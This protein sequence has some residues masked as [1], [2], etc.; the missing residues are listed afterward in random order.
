MR[1]LK[2][3]TQVRIGLGAVLAL[4]LALGAVA[5]VQ[6]DA[7]WSQT[8]NLYEHPLQVRRAVGDLKVDVLL[9]QRAVK[10]LCLA[11]SAQEQV[12]I[13]QEM[14]IREAAALRELEIL[15]DR[16]LGPHADVDAVHRHF[17]AWN[18]LRDETIQLVRAGKPAEAT[19]R[20]R[21]NDAGSAQV[22][23]L[24]GLIQVIDDFARNKG[25]S[26]YR[27]AEA[28][29]DTL[30]LRLVVVMGAIL[31]LGL[32]VSSLLLGRIQRPLQALTSAMLEYGQGKPD[33]RC[34]HVSENEFGTVATA[35]N[36]LADTV[37]AETVLKERAAELNA[38]MLRELESGTFRQGLLEALVRLTGSQVGA[39]YL[40]NPEKTAYQ[41]L[42]SIGLGGAARAAFSAAEREGEFGMALASGKVQHIA[43]IPAN[44]H[45]TFGAVS[46]DFSPKEILTIP[47]LSGGETPAMIS[48]ASLHGYAGG[49]VRLVEDMQAALSAWINGMLA[50]RRILALNDRLAD[51]NS[52]LEAQKNEL[53]AQASELGQQNVELEQQKQQLDQSNRLKTA[54]LSNMSHELRTPLNS[55]IALSGVLHRR[56]DKLIPP[57]ELGYLE[58]IERNGRQLLALINDVLD[59]AR[60]EAGREDLS[61]ERFS[62]KQ[63]ADELV[64]TLDPQAREKNIE[65]ESTVGE[66]LPLPVS[67]R[68]K[69]RHIL[70]NLL[71]NAVKFTEIGR[72]ELS[73]RVSE[74]G[75]EVSVTDT[76][77][78]IAADRL[79]IIFDE[80][81]QADESTSRR[82][83]GTGLGLAIAKKYAAMLGG[84]I[85]VA[86]TPGKG[87]TF[88]LVLPLV[89]DVDGEAAAPVAPR[90]SV[91]S[92]AL[93]P[94]H[95]KG[96]RLLLVEDSEPAIVQMMD[97][98]SAQGYTID[99]A[100][101]GREAL[102]QLEAVLPDAV[103]LD[104]MMP[105]VDG[106]AVLR[107]IREMKKSAQLPVLILTAKHVT[108]K[109][110]RFLR[111][112][113][114]HQLIQK[115]DISRTELLTAVAAMV[116][117][118]A[119]SNPLA[120][121]RPRPPSRPGKPLVLVVED[122]PDNLLTAR[123]LLRDDYEVIE[124]EDGVAAL[125]QARA[126]HPDLV[127][128]DISLPKM[129]GIQ[130]LRAMRADAELAHIPVIALTASA[131]KGS[132]EEI[133]AHGFDGYISKPIDAKTFLSSLRGVFNGPE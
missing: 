99:V 25:D 95:G 64:S 24:M 8:R 116:T 50:N 132:R 45:L 106:F 29:R 6:G 34:A 117:P 108:I 55:V 78:G 59:L 37:Q 76:G 7:F 115:G 133:L 87:S 97:I 63:L 126:H 88:T 66:D 42:E 109:D 11:E 86:S 23:V 121:P 114:I 20:S 15:R 49:A 71:A 79:E 75:L 41:H 19:A 129:D 48:L 103:I 84:A 90:A 83:G 124:A 54:F 17:V 73:A 32:T 128:M 70:Q 94:G 38:A 119:E 61:L 112:N 65:L 18:T 130:A 98:L 105:D 40:L 2:I 122:K 77:I 104:L 72:V 44:T 51:Q 67:D 21:R 110:L 9:I 57:E 100:R 120:R 14:D 4:V 123:A 118:P 96:K 28:Q 82:Y 12:A 5:W 85:R 47:L 16:Y 52:E 89:L 3:G 53:G 31:L 125:A 102:A 93:A 74:R 30:R 35:F 58:V 92:A 27:T 69:C 39:V 68:V 62:L 91:A 43:Q 80:F 33:A 113:H 36:T 10:D 101:G 13:L 107:A 60:I 127:L 131:M 22:D 26:L 111:G 1:D 46:G 56:L 81:R